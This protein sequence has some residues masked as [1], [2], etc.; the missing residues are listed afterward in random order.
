MSGISVCDL[1]YNLHEDEDD[2][3]A[4]VMPSVLGSGPR[5]KGG[6]GSVPESYHNTGAR[7]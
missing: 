4:R 2:N 1:Q 7:V 6:L 5:A 3:K